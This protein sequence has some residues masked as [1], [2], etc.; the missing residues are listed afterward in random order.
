[1]RQIFP[2]VFRIRNSVWLYWAVLI[3]TVP[4]NWLLASAAAAVFH[5]IGHYCAVLV[6]NGRIRTVEIGVFGT[7]MEAEGISGLREAICVLSGPAVSL[8]LILFI[9]R[10]PLL[11]LCG[12]I[13]GVFNLLPFYPLDG[14]RVLRC[15]TRIQ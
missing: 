15:I 9:Q 13:Q 8:L 11:G 6:L 10:F 2:E 1:M 4:T 14:G 12:L 3:L 7:V 5:E